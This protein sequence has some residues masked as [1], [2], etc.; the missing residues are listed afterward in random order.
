MLVCGQKNHKFLHKGSDLNP[1]SPDHHK[2]ANEI[3]FCSANLFIEVY[4]YKFFLILEQINAT[5]CVTIHEIAKCD[6]TRDF[7]KNFVPDPVIS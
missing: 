4:I 6:K 2:I 1:V 5:I 7:H 3:R